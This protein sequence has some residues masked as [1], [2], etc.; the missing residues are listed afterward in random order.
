MSPF[1]QT[2]YM[3]IRGAIPQDVASL[4]SRYTVFDQGQRFLTEGENS[5][6]ADTHS[7]YAD[8]LMESLLQQLR[9]TIEN[10]T[11][12][13]LYPTYSY[14]RLYEVGSVLKKHKDRPSCEISATI[15]LGFNY[16]GADYEWPIFIDGTPI[17]MQPG[18]L[19]IYKGCELT[20]WRDR[21]D[22]PN[23]SWHSQAFIHYVDANG[24][25]VEFKYDKRPAIGYNPQDT[26]SKL[27]TDKKI[28]QGFF[29]YK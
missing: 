21:F 4:L 29:H 8:P 12:L 17:V 11:N 18:D 14:Y 13:T 2:G 10:Y 20:H 7:K 27:R 23:G 6:F 22:A 9:P 16:M 1:D 19:V 24:S 5:Q 26:V 3:L 25:N 28:R 15:C